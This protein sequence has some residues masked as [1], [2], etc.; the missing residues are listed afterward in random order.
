M[1]FHHPV[2]YHADRRPSY[3]AVHAH[4]YQWTYAEVVAASHAVAN[5]LL[6]MGVQPGE[7]VG[8]LGLNSAAHL[9]IFLAASRIGA[10]TVSVNFRL[11]PPEIA[12]ILDDARAKVLF[13]TDNMIDE[14]ITA[15]M[16]AREGETTLIA[17]REDAVHQLSAVMAGDNTRVATSDAIV[18]STPVMQLY[19]S[20]TTGKPKGVVRHGGG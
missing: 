2:D 1:L 8:V 20:G 16:A 15:M 6:N 11:A 10:V 12:F 18:E 17:N 13:V 5:Q 4:D 19:T 3:P 9:A 7:R 14:V